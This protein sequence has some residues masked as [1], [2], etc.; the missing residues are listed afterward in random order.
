MRENLGGSV[1]GKSM[2]EDEEKRCWP[3]KTK[4]RKREMKL[5]LTENMLKANLRSSLA[6][7]EK[8]ARNHYEQQQKYLKLTEEY[9]KRQKDI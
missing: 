7:I 2:K 6:N 3:Q 9:F 1:A 4:L 5:L 8:Q